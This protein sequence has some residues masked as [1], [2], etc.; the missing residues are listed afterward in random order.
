MTDLRLA[1]MAIV[2]ETMQGGHS[3]ESMIDI[4]HR[5]IMILGDE[6]FKEGYGLATRQYRPKESEQEP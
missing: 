1:A 6:H 4:V 5:H 2:A 3:V